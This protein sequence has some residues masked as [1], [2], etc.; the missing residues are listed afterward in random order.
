MNA[1]GKAL[2]LALPLS[3]VWLGCASH[4][5][6]PPLPTDPAALE[7]PA[8]GT[9]F[10]IRTDSFEVPAGVEEQDCYFFK[11][12]DVA[13]AAG[14]P[15][16]EPVNLHRVQIV[17]KEGSHHMNIFRVRTI[18]GLDPTKG[19]VRGQNGQSECF[20]SPN[21]AD[22]PLV[23]NTQ[24]KG[25]IDWTYPDGVANVLDSS[26]WLMLQTHYVNASTQKVPDNKGAVSVNFYTLPK[27]EVKQELG[28]LFATNQNIRVCAKNPTPTFE[29]GCQIKSAAPVT[30][31]GANG[32]FHGRGKE[33]SI[34]SWDG[35][36]SSTPAESQRFYTSKQWDDPPMLR[37]PE[38]NTDIQ[39]NGGIWY[40]CSYQWAPPD[41]AVGGCDALNA[42]DK[43]KNKITDDTQLDCC[44]AFGPIVDKNE[45][46]N[47]FVYYYPKQDNITCQ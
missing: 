31:I 8:A 37:S 3:A 43:V 13:A 27:S 28:T 41:P 1:F 46:C 24:Q 29:Q 11:V 25:D 14:L 34:Y 19:T 7:A 12:G 6:D 15:S 22:W 42:Y 38:L 44:Y 16:N 39:P 36:Q 4:H 30:V 32:H 2:A 9:G 23:A 40:S 21:W 45:H 10:Q 33:F 35:K 47:A 20:K 17:Q 5:S 18:K 26:E